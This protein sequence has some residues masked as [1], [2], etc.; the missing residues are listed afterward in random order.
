MINYFVDGAWMCVQ[1]AA[2]AICSQARMA[3]AN[4]MTLKK[5]MPLIKK[6]RQERNECSQATKYI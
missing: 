3:G 2:R 4:R 1:M 6:T 5:S